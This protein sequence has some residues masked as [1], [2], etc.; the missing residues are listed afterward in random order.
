[1]KLSRYIV[2][3]SIISI[4]TKA[5]DCVTGNAGVMGAAAAELQH[6]K[7]GTEEEPASCA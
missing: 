3:L 4:V 5:C 6:F 7:I 2:H 1:L